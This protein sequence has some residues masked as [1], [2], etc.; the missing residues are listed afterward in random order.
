MASRRQRQPHRQQAAGRG[1]QHDADRQDR[2]QRPVIVGAMPKAQQESA[3]HEPDAEYPGE[4]AATVGE[5]RVIARFDADAPPDQHAQRREPR[6]V[7]DQR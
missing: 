5:H 3:R 7:I 6:R 2:P 4:R 1:R